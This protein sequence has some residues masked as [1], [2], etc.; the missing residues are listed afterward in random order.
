MR[1]LVLG[2]ALLL[3]A[4]GQTSAP[5]LARGSVLPPVELRVADFRITPA[6]IRVAAAGAVSFAVTNDGPTPHNL[7]IRDA[8]GE[9][10]FGTPELRPGAT[11]A[12]AGE[13]GSGSYIAFCS[14][15]GHESLGMRAMVI[16]GP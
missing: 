10:L 16:V 6:E 1:S 2:A 12:V 8:A 14:L 5:S 7:T 15:P 3:A 4:C 9:V 13:L 11:G